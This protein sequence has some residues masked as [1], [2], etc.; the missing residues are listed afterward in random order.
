MSNLISVRLNITEQQ[1][2]DL[3]RFHETTEDGQGYDVPKERM[4]SLASVGLVRWVGGSRYE[5]TD[6]G[7]ELRAFLAQPAEQHQGE[8]VG[9]TVSKPVATGAYWIR[10]NGLEREA[11]IEVVEDEGELRCNLHQRTTDS[12]F[13][14][15]YSIDQLSD[16]FEWRG[17][18][19]TRPA[20]QP[21]VVADQWPKLDKPALMGAGR[22]SAGLS[23]RLVVE[24]AQ[25]NYE[26]EVTP[27]NE[28]LRIATG[29][30]F[31]ALLRQPVPPGFQLVPAAPT[32]DMIVA[33]AEAW[34]SKRQT[35]DDPDMLDAYRDML[36]AAPPPT[37]KPAAA[38]RTSHA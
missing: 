37:F 28:A 14:Y 5:F 8:P 32:D 25:R 23:A 33:F 20:E 9:W 15:G 12:D 34:Y 36:A 1:S 18:L 13:G 35:I 27:E 10:G 2:R 11:L 29:K 19:Y 3:L 26:Y 24:A 38:A 17:P 7:T 30:S 22:F 6:A 4:K 21:A 31:L 16:E